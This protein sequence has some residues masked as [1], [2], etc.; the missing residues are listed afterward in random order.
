MYIER[1]SVRS[2]LMAFD[3]SFFS[4][5]GNNIFCLALKS[6]GARVQFTSSRCRGA[7]TGSP[8]D[9][10]LPSFQRVQRGFPGSRGGNPEGAEVIPSRQLFRFQLWSFRAGKRR[11]FRVFACT[12]VLCIRTRANRL[13]AVAVGEGQCSRTLLPGIQQVGGSVVVVGE[14]HGVVLQARQAVQVQL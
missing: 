14:G 10:E 1:L 9:C 11:N 6:S 5:Y 4:L 2:K 8:L 13:V 12:C 7:V 3:R